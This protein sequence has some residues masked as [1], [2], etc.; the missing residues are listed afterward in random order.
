MINGQM[1]RR[2]PG[3]LADTL[4]RCFFAHRGVILI[5]VVAL[6]VLS[7]CGASTGDASSPTA[8]STQMIPTVTSQ[9][10]QATATKTGVPGYQIKV[11]FSKFP[12]SLQNYV[13]VFPVARISPTIA[14]ATFSIQLL[15]AGPTLDERSEGYFSE[16]NSILTGP[17]ICNGNYPTGG[18]D[19]TITLNMKGATTEQG[20]ATLQ[21]CRATQSPG[22]GADARIKAEITATLL[23]FPN[24]KKVVILTSAGRF[25]GNEGGAD[26]YLK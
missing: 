5:S 11:Y 19:F 4:A 22:I 2:G 20:T 26:A 21:F 13:V 6:L 16:L 12:D 8:T 1:L 9:T 23:Q 7:A 24:I 18:P 17:S 3:G 15:I 25:F 14:V 10:P